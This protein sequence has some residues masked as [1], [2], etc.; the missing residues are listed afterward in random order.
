M[1]RCRK[2]TTPHLT[3]ARVGRLKTETPSMSASQSETTA[4]DVPKASW[5][6]AAYMVLFSLAGSW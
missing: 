5:Q 2:G 6:E 4:E 3:P 1:V